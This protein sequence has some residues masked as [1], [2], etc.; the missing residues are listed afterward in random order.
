M[1]LAKIIEDNKKQNVLAIVITIIGAIILSNI[2]ITV[3]IVAVIAFSKDETQ[4]YTN[5]VDY[6]TCLLKMKQ[7]YETSS[8]FFKFPENLEENKILD[9]NC[10]ISSSYS[11]YFYV[12]CKYD[13][14][15]FE[16]EKNRIGNLSI[17]SNDTLAD[18]YSLGIYN[19]KK[20]LK[21]E[22]KTPLYTEEGFEYPC[23]VTIFFGGF[24]QNGFDKIF[25]G[26]D[27]K[28]LG[29]YDTYE[30]VLFDEENKIVAYVYNKFYTWEDVNIDDIYKPNGYEVK[31]EDCD[32]GIIGYNMYSFEM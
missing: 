12:V 15:Q 13:N 29:K 30:Y 24:E 16:N 17:S 27:T 11:Y 28:L 31:A 25:F 4:E 8:S 26:D 3:I 21:D 14:V 5:K 20:V 6:S 32:N 19:S 7:A 2:L 9:F 1:K 23:Y 18:S 22:I 10:K